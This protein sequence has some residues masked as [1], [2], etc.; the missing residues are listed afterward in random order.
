MN[1]ILHLGL[2]AFHRAHQAVYLQ[3]LH[4]LGAHDWTLAGGNIRRDM[5]QTMDALVAQRGQYTLETIAPDGATQYERI[6]SICQIVPFDPQLEAL[7]ELGAQPETRIISF[8]VTE[9]GY[10]LDAAHRLDSRHPDVRGDL[11][12]RTRCT[13]Y[14]ALAGIVAERARRG[15]GP[16]TLLS[17]DNLRSNGTRLRSCLLDFLDLCGEGTASTWVRTHTTCP[18]SMVDRITPRLLPDAVERV[19]AATGWADR[20]PVMSERF[21]Q[22]VIE[23]DFANGR[24]DWQ[25]VGVELVQSVAPYEEAKIRLLN[26]SHSGIAWAGSLIGLCFIHEGVRV[27]AIRRMA[28]DYVTQD[29]IPVLSPSPIDLAAYRDIVLERFANPHLRDGNPRVAMDGYSKVPGFI[30]PTIRERLER[31][32]SIARA[33]M[34]PALFFNFLRR[35]HRGGLADAYQDAAMDPVAAHALFDAADPLAAFCRDPALW[36]PLAGAPDLVGAIRSADREVAAFVANA[37]AA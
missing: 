33:A 16:V 31:S 37:G 25:R 6:R 13:L 1:R 21:I 5:S 15:S 34:L 19:R 23:D 2:G 8:T 29:A 32:Q 7:I 12:G 24:P 18:N 22:W 26:A 14:G 11:E 17:C 9:A 10:F 27:P 3:R 36:G 20:A 4:D 35:W 28:Y 30:V